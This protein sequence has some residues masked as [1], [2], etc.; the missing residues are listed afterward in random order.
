[1]ISRFYADALFL[2]ATAIDLERGLF[3]SNVYE[4]GIKQRMVRSARK[5]ILLADHTKFGNQSLCKFAALDAVHCIVTDQQIAPEIPIALR[6][7]DIEVRLASL[8]G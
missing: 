1:M 4:V 3:N 8:R 2:A 6:D 7:H 5:V